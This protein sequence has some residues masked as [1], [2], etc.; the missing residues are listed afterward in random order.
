MASAKRR[1]IVASIWTLI[2]FG[3]SQSLRLVSNLILTRLLAPDLFGLM[4]L[5]TT[6]VVGLHLFSDVG[7][8]ASLIQNRRGNDPKFYNTAWTLQVVRGIS[9][10]LLS[11]PV[12]YICVQIY[13][14]PRLWLLI[15]VALGSSV[16][17][18][19][20]SVAEHLLNRQVKQG[21]QQMLFFTTQISS[22]VVTAIWAY[23][24]QSIWALVAGNLVS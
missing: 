12:A 23:F 5:I 19:F 6:F 15:V 24:Q 10:W 9:L 17:A 18:G 3:G 7:I 4:S 14:E 1:A 13:D 2:G 22:I 16:F 8:G 21:R 11:F 20:E